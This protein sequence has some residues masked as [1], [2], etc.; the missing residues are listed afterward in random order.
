M[1]WLAGIGLALAISIGPGFG[2]AAKREPIRVLIVTGEADLPYHV[3]QETTASMRRILD[4][5]GRF[6][7]RTNEEPRGITAAALKGYQVLVLN[8]NGPRWPKEAEDA[9][10][11]FIH[12]G[13]GFVAVHQASYGAFFGQEMRD[14]HWQAGP[15]G[16][17]WAAFPEIIGARWAP[18]DIGHARRTV[19]QVDWK[20]SN[21]ALCAGLPPSF[22]ANDELYHKMQ[23]GPRAQVLADAMSPA[24]LGGT[25][26]REPLVWANQFGKGRVVFTPLGHDAL[27]WYEPGMANL[28]T[29]SVE[30]AATGTGTVS[31]V[32]R[33]HR[34]GDPSPIRLLVVTGGHT[35]PVAF[36][37]MIE[38]LPGVVW[39]HATSQQEAFASSIEDRFDA[40]LLHDMYEVTTEQT[41]EHL[42]SFIESGKGVLSLHH[43]IVDYT[44]WPWW[45]Q[46]VTGGKY[47]VNA[48]GRHT[49]SSYREGLD[50]QVTPIPGK[51]DHP[52]LRG[53]GPLWVN[54][55]LYK[56][57]EH[58]AAI[59][60]LMETTHPDNDRPVVY[61]GPCQTARVVYVQLGHSADTMNN[62][63]FRRLISN[64]VH[65]IA[66]K[67][68]SEAQ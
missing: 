50:F 62:P 44:D 39:T 21:Q 52:V 4:A 61:V 41:R 35:Y 45:Y 60:V 51:G 40:V 5:S 31:P 28:L 34:A 55:E 32:S 59:E 68:V 13:G 47:F 8:Y 17:G 19:F 23:L 64:A 33:E 14:G 29:R 11:R 49:A 7:V 53:V 58:S 30:W 22:M 36:Y 20:D 10:E 6:D 3:W 24:D 38:S 42:K 37:A 67:P 56:G 9:V 26:R 63:G 27:A 43:S 66:R 18:E 1:K 57:M 16:S 48:D 65:W 12:N 54:D 25:G 15:E 46:E 2:Q